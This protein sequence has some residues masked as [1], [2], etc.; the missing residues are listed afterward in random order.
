VQVKGA[1]DDGQPYLVQVTGQ[2]ARPVIGSQR[3]AAMLATLPD[4]DGSN[5]RAVV[6]VLEAWT[7][8]QSVQ[9]QL[10]APAGPPRPAGGL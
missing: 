3:A 2:A 6:A 10:P 4:L 5:I 9:G 7:T 8:V 1:F